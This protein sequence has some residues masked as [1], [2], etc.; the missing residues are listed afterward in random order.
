MSEDGEEEDLWPGHNAE[1]CTVCGL[2][3]CGWF[4][5][6]NIDKGEE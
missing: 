3:G 1:V 2:P 5:C 4:F 6:F